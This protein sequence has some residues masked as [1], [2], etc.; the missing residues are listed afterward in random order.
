MPVALGARRT[1]I[2]AETT[3]VIVGLEDPNIVAPAIPGS[4]VRYVWTR[5][6][7]GATELIY[8][9]GDP[10]AFVCRVRA[11]GH[12]G[13]TY[14]GALDPLPLATFFP[15]DADDLTAAHHT[16]TL[17]QARR[18][19][20]RMVAGLSEAAYGRPDALKARVRA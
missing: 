3:T 14:P 1:V 15:D 9:F 18:R 11:G 4:A 2:D 19:W 16:W 7:A 12:S 20:E 8:S 13:V 17:G 6:P 10:R 5:M